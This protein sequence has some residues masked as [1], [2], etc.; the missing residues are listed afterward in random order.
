MSNAKGDK[1]SVPVIEPI[2]PRST[3]VDIRA[4]VAKALDRLAGRYRD[5]LTILVN[6]PQRR[7]DSGAVLRVVAESLDP[8][9][10]RILIAT[11]T[12]NFSEATKRS[13][14]QRLTAGLAFR[15][16]GWHD[17]RSPDLVP[18]GGKWF[19][20]PWLIESSA[21]LAVGSVE[22][23]YFAGFTGAHKTLTVGC[24]SYGDIERNH[25]L[26]LE[27]NCRPGRLEANGVYDGILTMLAALAAAQCV[28]AINLMQTGSRIIAA[29]G[30]EPVA[31]MQSLLPV[32]RDTYIHR[33]DS[34]ADAIVAEVTGPLGRSFYQADKGIKNSEWAVRDG[35]TIV[36]VAPCDEGIGQ[37][38]FV[39]LMREAADYDAA[40]EIVR[41]R[42]YRLGDHKAVKLR[43][44][45]DPKYRGVRVLAVSEGLSAEHAGLLGLTKA[46]SV[47]SAL[48]AAGVDPSRD[49]VW[50]IRDAGT[51]CLV[52]GDN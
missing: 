45:T 21:L 16:T 12:H 31:A 15:E 2:Q 32:V 14:E 27:C 43:Y 10:A 40:V 38:D 35:G 25:A 50:Q 18:V 28:S 34:P 36:L 46:D 22:P 5:R 3:T 19:A 48:A 6:D 1:W 8:A 26:V 47:E 44:L 9:N 49:R 42:G 52:T 39:K 37:D 7:T 11:G 30:G 13:F 33:I 29:A 41:T 51:L 17:A 20:H 23:H 4:A 24:A